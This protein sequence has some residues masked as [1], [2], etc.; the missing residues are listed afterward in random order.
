MKITIGRREFLRWFGM[1]AACDVR[2]ARRSA[3]RLLAAPSTSPTRVLRLHP[4]RWGLGRHA[5]GRS[6]QRAQ[7]AGRARCR[8]TTPTPGRFAAGR[9]V[10]PVDSD[11]SSFAI[12][13]PMPGCNIP[14]GPT[15]GDLLDLHDR[16]L[17][18]NGLAMNTRLQPP[19]PAQLRFLR[20]GATCRASRAPQ[21]SINTIIAAE[22]GTEQV[23][24]S[25]SVQF[26]SSFVG[27]NLDRRAAPLQVE[28]IGSI[29]R[30]L[31]GAAAQYEGT[32]DRDEVTAL[33]SDES[34]GLGQA[35]AY[36]Q[37]FDGMALQLGNL[38]RMLAPGMQDLFNENLPQG[39]APG[40]Q[41]QVEVP[42]AAG[43]GGGVRRRGHAAQCGARGELLRPA[44]STRTPTIYIGSRRRCSRACLISS[45]SWSRRWTRRH[46]RCCRRLSCPKA[47]AHPGG[48]RL[49]S[50]AADQHRRR[51]R[52]LSQQ[53]RRFG[54]LPTLPWQPGLRQ[55][56]PRPALADGG[57]KVHRRRARHRAARPLWRRSSRR[58]GLIRGSD[59][60]RWRSGARALAR[61]TVLFCRKRLL[62]FLFCFSAK[63]LHSAQSSIRRRLWP[64]ARSTMGPARTQGATLHPDRRRR[65]SAAGDHQR[66][67][68]AVSRGPW[69]WPASAG[70]SSP[71]R[72]SPPPP[73]ANGRWLVAVDD[74][75]APL[76]TARRAAL[77]A[78]RGALRPGQG[79][80]ALCQA[81]PTRA[82][83][84]RRSK[85]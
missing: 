38:D 81:G 25:I 11:T 55:E 15:I 78:H 67:G 1:G 80:H 46:T 37:V 51:A 73:T 8:R 53:L 62:L 2:S 32:P 83:F 30:T 48:Q 65:R 66:R 22:L 47:H 4:C 43:A 24:P 58:S 17:V 35:A 56:R 84:P 19:R 54:D 68:D 40:A 64:F 31:R 72:R 36:P 5:V 69:R 74:A 76:S 20:P 33:L 39:G 27:D 50:Y 6:A 70:T 57:Q 82:A 45:R 23:L 7:G 85:S 29:G 34:R 49:L 61:M 26:P 44:G 71:R 18:V 16:L 59:V 63:W 52:P 14:F 79:V 13:Q 42:R 41:L 28:R 77:G 10:L 3:G 9:S 75:G 21:S 60:A 12:P